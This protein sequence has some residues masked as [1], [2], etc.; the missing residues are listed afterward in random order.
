VVA[1]DTKIAS[2]PT[3]V[4]GKMLLQFFLLTAIGAG[5]TAY[6]WDPL[7]LDP[8]GDAYPITFD[9]SSHGAASFSGIQTF[10]HSRHLQCFG[11]DRPE[12]FDVALLGLPFD[13]L[14]SYRPGARF[15]PSGIRKGSQRMSRFGALARANVVRL[16][17]S[18]SRPIQCRGG[19]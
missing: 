11:G 15:G 9:P 6:V 16:C 1:V 13:T 3:V 19:S 17:P 18:A 2:S 7:V 8:V 5:A 4:R 14:A 12:T 10:A